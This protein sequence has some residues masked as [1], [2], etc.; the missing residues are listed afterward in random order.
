MS[1][2]YTATATILPH[3]LYELVLAGER[4]TDGGVCVCVCENLALPSTGYNYIMC[5]LHLYKLAC[6]LGVCVAALTSH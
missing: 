5:P 2:I 6:A 4:Q 3:C 1:V